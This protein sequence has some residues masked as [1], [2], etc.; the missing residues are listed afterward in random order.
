[1]VTVEEKLTAIKALDGYIVGSLMLHSHNDTGC[2]FKY[3]VDE[4]GIIR[5]HKVFLELNCATPQEDFLDVEVNNEETIEHEQVATDGT[6]YVR[7]TEKTVG[8][9]MQVKGFEFT[10]PADTTTNY[11][12]VWSKDIEMVGGCADCYPWVEATPT[13]S[14]E[15]FYDSKCNM[16]VVDK[17]NILGYGAGFVLAT[18]ATDI[19]VSKLMINGCAAVSTTA[20]ILMEGLYIRVSVTNDS[21]TAECVIT[22]SIKYYH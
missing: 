14:V 12:M 21:D 8:K 16:Q 22:G 18:F 13:T 9:T 15:D 4:A 7:V 5:K 1:M 19:P 6:Q 20:F 10:C 3:L 2:S 11:D 17:D